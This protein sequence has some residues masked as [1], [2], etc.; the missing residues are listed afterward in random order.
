MCVY[1]L[2]DSHNKPLKKTNEA[3]SCVRHGFSGALCSSL[4]SC[5]GGVG[6]GKDLLNNT[7]KFKT[8]LK[9]K[10]QSELFLAISR[11]VKYK[12]A[13]TLELCERTARTSALAHLVTHPN[14]KHS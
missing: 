13:L 6:E 3:N 1:D 5:F 10:D 14:Q 9:F 11:C 2:F 8:V 7:F 4:S 12:F